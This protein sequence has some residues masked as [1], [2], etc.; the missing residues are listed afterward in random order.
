M[1]GVA[2][3]QRLTPLEVSLL[4]LD[5]AHAPAHV[6]T[7]DIFDAQPD[8]LDYE[9]LIAL[10]R[11]RIAYVPRYR[12]RV[13][14]VPAR[15]AAP[16]WVDDESFD[17][18]FHVRR[19]ALP[20]PGTLEQLREFV[21]RVVARRMDR[22]R[23]LWE[24]YVVE[25][26]EGDR[27]AVVAKTH[28]TLV[29]GVDNV[30]IGQVL[31]DARPEPELA[32]PE[33]WRP[34]PEPG[35]AELVAGALWESA[36]DPLLAW[37]NVQ[38]AATSALG[39]AVAVGEAVG[40]VGS[41]VVELVEDALLGSRPRSKS[42]LVGVVSEQ[43]RVAL[44][45]VPL[46][47]LKAVRDEHDHTINDVI[48]AAVAGALRSWLLTR[49]ESVPNGRELTALVPMSVTEDDGEPTSLG[50]Q[51]AP[52]LQ[53]LP[54]GEVNALMRLHQVA[55]S[56]QA[57]KDTGRAVDA[58]TLSDIAGFAPTTLHALG[59]RVSNEVLRRQH[60]VLVTNVPGPQMALYA[61]G[62]RLVASYPVLPL[63]AGHLL[64]IGVTSYDG[65]VFFG[66][67]ADRDAVGDLDVLAQCLDDAVEELL[68]TTVR[69]R[70][71]RQPTRKASAAAKKAAASKAASKAAARQEAR[72]G[73]GQR[74]AAMRNLANRAVELGNATRVPGAKR[75]P[76]AP[77]T[78]T[79]RKL[80]TKDTATTTEPVGKKTVSAAKRAAPVK[81]TAV[82]APAVKKAPSATKSAESDEKATAAKTTPAAKKVPPKKAPA[83][84]ATAE[85]A[86]AKKTTAKKTT[87]K[88]APAKQATPTPTTPAEGA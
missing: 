9:R 59:V 82:K 30:D 34:V 58:R 60:D 68:D 70:A 78:S 40:G 10:I 61:A 17:L 11:E 71:L 51:V 3:P 63:G 37:Q 52:H 64:A 57:H 77:V 24:M 14:D 1:E 62:E 44:V 23:P 20:R 65:H 19:S 55:Y 56:T 85:K 4:V 31:L 80:P 76:P 47:E 41:T 42:P 35:A 73:A 16:V 66:L 25:G 32:T 39:V 53:P 88:K 54:I 2:M 48:L 43:R 8:G 81:R 69:A 22:S 5:T 38:G 74:R 26:L 12:Q 28:L 36:N 15:L 49:G 6:A 84:N 72:R 13:R 21:G 33:S 45:S 79:A 75:T 29:D 46:A 50:S 27:F 87:A 67:T 86:P 18:T 7:V 83:A